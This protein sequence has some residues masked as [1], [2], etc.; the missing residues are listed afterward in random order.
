[1]S[2]RHSIFLY[3]FRKTLLHIKAWSTSTCVFR[4]IMLMNNIT[5]TLST[6][7]LIY[8]SIMKHVTLRALRNEAAC[9]R[10]DVNAEKDPE[11]LHVGGSLAKA[12]LSVT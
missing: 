12:Q 11:C 8:S 2:A 1:M 6:Y 4:N 10:S 3:N 7:K 9:V 5:S